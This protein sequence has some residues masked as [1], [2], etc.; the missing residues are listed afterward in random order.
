MKYK[1]K[2]YVL[3][4]IHVLIV[5]RHKRKKNYTDCHVN[6]N[7]RSLNYI[8]YQW[9]LRSMSFHNDFNTSSSYIAIEFR[10]FRLQ[11]FWFF[12]KKLQNKNYLRVFLRCRPSCILRNYFSIAIGR[13]IHDSSCQ[14]HRPFRGCKSIG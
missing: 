1:Q 3:F 4:R 11:F 13:S 7:K 6:V 9:N 10:L 12:I 2:I 5:I 14:C 8:E